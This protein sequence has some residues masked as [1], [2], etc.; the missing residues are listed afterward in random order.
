[1]MSVKTFNRAANMYKALYTVGEV[2]RAI[3]EEK[4]SLS[5]FTLI[6]KLYLNSISYLTFLC[7]SMMLQFLSK[8][9][10]KVNL[11]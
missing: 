7:S 9:C 11:F 4:Y 2:N 8:I 10:L 3:T 1:M 5:T 6:S